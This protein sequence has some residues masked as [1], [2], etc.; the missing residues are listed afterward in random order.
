MAYARERHSICCRS[1]T[2]TT[3]SLHLATSYDYRL[4]G[5]WPIIS[6]QV[7]IRSPH[8]HK[9]IGRLVF[10]TVE[11]S[12]EW[13]PLDYDF[14]YAFVRK[15]VRCMKHSHRCAQHYRKSLATNDQ[16]T[17]DQRFV[18]VAHQKASQQKNPEHLHQIFTPSPPQPRTQ[19][20][21]SSPP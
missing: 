16:S 13:R 18:Q 5:L 19:S 8:E 15:I 1:L 21:P 2:H 20:S 4:A 11:P 10:A 6:M 12:L 14:P 17:S 7:A 3:R 9:G